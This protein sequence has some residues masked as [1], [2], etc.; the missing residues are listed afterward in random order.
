MKVKA[1]RAYNLT[2]SPSLF[3]QTWSMKNGLIKIF[4]IPSLQNKASCFAVGEKVSS[5]LF[6]S[7]LVSLLLF[8]HGHQPTCFDDDD[9]PCWHNGGRTCLA[10]DTRYTRRKRDPLAR[11]EDLFRLDLSSLWPSSLG[12]NDLRSTEKK[13][14]F[15]GEGANGNCGK[16]GEEG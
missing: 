1:V 13:S 8:L 3:T 14:C 9:R 5:F 12:T 7:Q 11:E 6:S 10:R 4:A 15:G 2:Y 16:E